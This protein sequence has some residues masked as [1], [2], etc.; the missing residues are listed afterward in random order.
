MYDMDP[1]HVKKF[2][3]EKNEAKGRLRE[4]EFQQVLSY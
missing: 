2:Q 1:N 3:G 4:K